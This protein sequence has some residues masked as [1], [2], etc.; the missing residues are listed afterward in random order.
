MVEDL[1]I[2]HGDSVQKMKDLDE[3]NTIQIKPMKVDRAES[4]KEINKVSSNE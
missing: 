3:E 4:K 2:L 1:E